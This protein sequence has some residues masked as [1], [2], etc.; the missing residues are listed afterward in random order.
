[1]G[2]PR[3]SR[4]THPASLAEWNLLAFVG[5]FQARWIQ[6]LTF[7]ELIADEVARMAAVESRILHAPIP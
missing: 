6:R 3:V 2:T 5:T 1:M 7:V 4:S